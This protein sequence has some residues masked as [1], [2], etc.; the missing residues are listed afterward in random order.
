M[1]SVAGILLA[2]TLVVPCALL[3]QQ[4]IVGINP[5]SRKQL[6]LYEPGTSQV[7]RQVSV[8]ELNLPLPASQAK[9]GF[10]S[11]KL[12]DQEYWVRSMHVRVRQLSKADCPPQIIGLGQHNSTP[13]AG[14]VG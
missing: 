2:L 11:L 14:A 5:S 3:A 13:G 6:D 12:H 9:P 1:K 4:E 7:L 8:S 10:F